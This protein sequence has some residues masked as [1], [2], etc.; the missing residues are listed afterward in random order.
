MKQSRPNKTQIYSQVP[1]ANLPRSSFRMPSN[2]KTSFN[3][4][5]LTPIYCR[6]VLP[7]DTVNMN[8]S[9]FVRMNPTVTPFMDNLYVDVHF[10][11]VP[12][13][14]VWDNWEKFNGE[15]DNPGD[16]IDFLIPQVVSPAVTG[17]D[18]ASPAADMGVRRGI[19]GL[20]HS[21]LPLRMYNL[22]WNEWYRSQ[23]LQDSAVVDKD[24]GPDTATDYASLLPRGKFHD[25]FTSCLPFPQKGDAVTIPQPDITAT[26]TISKSGDFVLNNS[27]VGSP[28][29]TLVQTNGS[30]AVTWNAAPTSTGSAQY[31]SGLDASTTI[32][33]DDALATINALRTAEAVQ[34]LL[35]KQARGGTRYTEMIRS[36][37]G[38]VSPDARLQRPEYL[39]GNSV[40][41][42]MTPVLQTSESGTTPQGNLAG[43][44]TLNSQNASFVKSFTEHG[45]IIGL[46]SA[47]SDIHYQ[48]GT[49][50]HWFRSTLY[51][52]YVPSL[53]NLGE[54]AVLNREIFTQG[55]A[56]DDDVFGYIP[57]WD[58]LRFHPSRIGGTL[59][60]D[61][62]SSLDVWHL[63]EDF[64]ALP[65]L[66]D[67]FIKDAT[68]EL[69]VLSVTTE[70]TFI[71]DFHFDQ[72]WTRVM[73]INSIPGMGSR[74]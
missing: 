27:N 14:L 59:N 35:E 45:Y 4:S 28:N 50:R 67:T 29:R 53:A 16:S 33:N 61:T 41:V 7:G 72:T 44:G 65:V 49:D 6:E 38:V 36:H 64:E 54:Q 18:V 57:R 71:G 70:A 48:Q 51:D 73:P 23:D 62:P 8:M 32:L 15:Q 63:A 25:Y 56:A 30:T 42:N 68:P 74:F 22:I 31:V 13:R 9:N 24:N 66:N 39:G 34:S 12:N 21:A 3:A 47:R 19:P 52:F 46:V 2:Y 58:E 26:S 37:F 17:W 20:S 60:S 10:F 40:P 5:Y 43:M 11:F 69:R 1:R 55:T